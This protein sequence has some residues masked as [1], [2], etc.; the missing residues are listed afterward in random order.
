MRVLHVIPSVSASHGGPTVA[1]KLMVEGL[2]AA[3]VQ[4]EVATTA[5]PGAARPT[6]ASTNGVRYH[7]F[8][9]Q[10]RFYTIS[11]PLWGWLRREAAAFDLLHVHALFSFASTAAATAARRAGVPYVIRPLGTLAPYGLRQHRLLKSISL[12]LVERRALER[13]AALHCTSQLEANEIQAL[14][15]S[16]CTRIIPLGIDVA[17]FHEPQPPDWL[18]RRAPRLAGRRVLLFLS[19]ID[20][21]K[22]IEL[23]LA[24]VAQLQKES[25]KPVALVIAGAGEPAYLRALQQQAEQLGLTESVLWAGHLEDHDKRAALAAAHVFVLPSEAENFGIAVVEAM[26][27]GVPVVLSRDVALTADVTAAHAGIGIERNVPA[28]VKALHQL[29]RD[30]TLRAEMGRRACQLAQ[31]HFSQQIM[32]DRLLELYRSVA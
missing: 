25:T 1:L 14:G 16:T 4:V 21:K 17:R 15:L 7:Y 32:T 29:L 27:A 22:G 13:A 26:A 12:R 28:L 20:R 10:A 2:S 9:R 30:E 18:A 3:G 19:R 8:A 5:D 24:G 6:G 23:L 11:W 31:E